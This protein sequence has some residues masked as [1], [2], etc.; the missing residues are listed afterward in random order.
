MYILNID[1]NARGLDG[2]HD[3]AENGKNKIEGGDLLFLYF[4]LL[5]L[6]LV[7]FEEE[8][9]NQTVSMYTKWAVIWPQGAT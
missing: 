8:E 5:L 3:I 4:F 1:G 2:A 9:K 7:R 6:R